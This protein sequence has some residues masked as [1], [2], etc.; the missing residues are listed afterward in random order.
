QR[1]LRDYHR[2]EDAT[3]QTLVQIWRKLPKL[4]D[5]D[6]FE[7]WSYRIL[8]NT[9]YAEARKSRRHPDDLRLLDTDRASADSALSVADRDMLERAFERLSPEQRA[10]LVLQY[11]L[12]LGH[13]QIAEILGVPLGT[14]KS[15]SSAARQALR[16][17]LEADARPGEGRWS[18]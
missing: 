8:V 3:Q 1:I 4:A 10:V 12:D 17:A 18:A 14:V 5:P 7:G 9:C 11:Y 6:K 13:P 15:R 16:A 2:A